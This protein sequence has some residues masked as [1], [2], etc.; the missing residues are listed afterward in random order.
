[1]SKVGKQ[2][3]EYTENSSQNLTDESVEQFLSWGTDTAGNSNKNLPPRTSQ[4]HGVVHSLSVCGK[5]SGVGATYR[6]KLCKLI[7]VT[8]RATVTECVA[9]A[10]G[11]GGSVDHGNGGGGTGPLTKGTMDGAASMS[12]NQFFNCINMLFEQV[13]RLLW[14]LLP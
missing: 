12:L 5:L 6:K 14:G 3:N 9:D 13:L 8:T 11:T 4:I 2:L 1:M 10:G 7:S